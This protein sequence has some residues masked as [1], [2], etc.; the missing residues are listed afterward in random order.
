MSRITRNQMFMQFAE[1]ASRRATC[2]R[3]SVGAVL[4]RDKNVVSVG[5]NGPLA[6]EPHC[7]G[8]TCPTNNVCGRAIH[9]EINAIN[10]CEDHHSGLTMYVTESPCMACAARIVDE[11]RIYALYFL[12]LYRDPAGVDFLTKQIRVYRMTPTGY[13]ILYGTG[14]LVENIE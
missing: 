9:A 12:N 10:R 6:G 14:Q 4:V 7:T 5:Y 11:R 13:V 3:R 2:F 1:V 8:I